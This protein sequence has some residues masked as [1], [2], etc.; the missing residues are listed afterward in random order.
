MIADEQNVPHYVAA[1]DDTGRI[2]EKAETDTGQG[3]CTEAF[4]TGQLV[5]SVDL[6]VDR[7]W[8]ELAQA[9]AAY[10]VRAVL[11]VPVRLGT[12][13]VGTLDV[14]RD[15]PHEWDETERAAL[16]RYGD[17]VQATLAAAM[18]AHTAGELADQLQ[19]ALDYRVSIERGIG[20][21]MARDG[22][23]ALTAFN[24]LRQVARSTR[25]KIGVVAEELLRT[26]RLP[27]GR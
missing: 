19:Y 7:R 14:Y 11:G 18:A 2:L 8:P 3:P 20:Y 21:L 17:V 1:S 25:T 9:L 10:P 26:G 6:S 23:D 12:A 16:E 15:R 27:T 4:V 24:R 22:L 13:P 5:A